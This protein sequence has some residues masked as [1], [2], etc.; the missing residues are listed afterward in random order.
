MLGFGVAGGTAITA[1]DSLP[2]SPMYPVKLAMED[3]QLA[4]VGDTET[5][6]SLHTDL[7]AGRLRETQQ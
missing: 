6:V 5:A 2:D 3:V 1:A 7:A 4:M